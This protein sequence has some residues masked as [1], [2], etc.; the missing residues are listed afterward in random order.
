MSITSITIENF[1]GIR[2][3]VKFDLAPITLLYGPNSAGKSTLLQ[4]LAYLSDVIN[5]QKCNNPYTRA[6]STSMKLGGFAN[7]VNGHDLSKSIRITIEI[8]NL[9]SWNAV[10]HPRY[11]WPIG[12]SSFVEETRK[13]MLNFDCL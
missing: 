4:A 10:G 3:P 5:Y 12:Y 6:G 13:S 7:I 9:S 11:T 1:K 2:E 8:D